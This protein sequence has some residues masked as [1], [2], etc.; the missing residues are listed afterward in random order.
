MLD[1]TTT[2]EERHVLEGKEISAGHPCAD[3]FGANRFCHL[4]QSSYSTLRH[5]HYSQTPNPIRYT[6]IEFTQSQQIFD[7]M[8]DDGSV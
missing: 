4:K 3:R 6:R 7:S 5:I 1:G 2:L 8:N